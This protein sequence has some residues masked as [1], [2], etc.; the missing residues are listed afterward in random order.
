MSEPASAQF[1]SV[2]EAYR[3]WAPLYDATPNPL[4]SLEQRA[5]APMLHSAAGRDVVDLGCGTG[6]WLA[7]LSTANPR[8]MI[9]VDLSEDM[10]A[11]AAK[12][13]APAVRLVQADCL[14]TPLADRSS[15]WILA[16]FLLSYVDNL[17][18][19]AREAARI[20][21]PGAMIVVSDVHPDTRSYGWRRTFRSTDH[22]IEIQSHTYQ[23][24][25]LQRGM[26]D[27]GF[28]STFLHELSFGEEEKRIYIDA[29]RPELF[30]H[31]QGLPVMFIASYRR[32]G[33]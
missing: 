33:T 12:K 18:A 32:S 14:T 21:R 2:K 13:V 5:L 26:E 30:L 6:R 28:E 9:G 1:T 10:L 25:D 29:G 22:V 27:A 17:R 15:D 3:L 20:G 11:H 31:V 16:S 24:E 8:S 4:I 7:Q 19:F 23:I